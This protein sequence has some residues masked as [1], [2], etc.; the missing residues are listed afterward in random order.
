M[1]VPDRIGIW[2][3]VLVFEERGIKIGV[4]GAKSL[5]GRE[6]TNKKST[7]IL[8]S[9]PRFEAGATL[10]GGECSHHCATLAPLRCLRAPVIFTNF[11]E[12]IFMKYPAQVSL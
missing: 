5:G 1:C 4:P 8:V 12:F 3:E 2:T 10:V 7:Q 6:R 9:M 11:E